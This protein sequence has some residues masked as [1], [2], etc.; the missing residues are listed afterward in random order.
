[1][2]SFAA[3]DI[4]QDR[5]VATEAGGD[6]DPVREAAVAAHRCDRLAGLDDQEGRRHRHLY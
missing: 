4:D 3:L 6:P 2:S 1:M 5:I